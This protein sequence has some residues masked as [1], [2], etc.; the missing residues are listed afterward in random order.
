MS[1]RLIQQMQQKAIPAMHACRVLQ[2]SRSGFYAAQRRWQ[3]P[4]TLCRSSV[5]LR[6]VFAASGATYGSRRLR[7]SVAQ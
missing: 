4:V 2:V 6:A 7:A 1:Y 3:R 5:H